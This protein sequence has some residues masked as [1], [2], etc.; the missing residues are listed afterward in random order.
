MR[1][2]LLVVRLVAR[3]G[4]ELLGLEGGATDERTVKAREKMHNAA[5][6]AGMAFG[7]AFLGIV[8]A[9]AHVTGSTF[10]LIHGR[11]NATYLPHVIRYNGTVPTKLT[12]WPKYEHYVAPE[13]FQEIA[14]H[15]P[16]GAVH[17]GLALK[18]DEPAFQKK[19]ADNGPKAFV[20][21]AT[22]RQEAIPAAVVDIKGAHV[23]EV[24]A[25]VGPT[26]TFAAPLLGTVGQPTQKMI[27]ESKG[28]LSS[29]D[30]VGL[31]GLQ[32]R[33]DKDLRGV[34]GAQIGRA[35]V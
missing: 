5:T 14:K 7:N 3:D 6:I 17:Q 30:R 23:N 1:V 25:V 26:D 19:V 28:E 16:Q 10:H 35:H 27:D 24:S 29:I 8:H 21:G 2:S 13:R 4:R 31:S 32:S 34:P 22:V 18:I 20:V 12:S 33:Y 9:M 15:L 11:T